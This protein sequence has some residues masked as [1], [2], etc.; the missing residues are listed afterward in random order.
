LVQRAA[1]M[2]LI[3][4]G[5]AMVTYHMVGS[6]VV[7]VGYIENQAVHLAFLFLLTFVSAI[8]RSG[9]VVWQIANII[10]AIIGVGSAA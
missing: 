8:A 2:I 1:Q 10:F 3:V 7:L 9:N 5:L 4:A 6:Q